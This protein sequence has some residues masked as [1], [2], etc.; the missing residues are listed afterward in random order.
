MI[1]DT[2]IQLATV[3]K[4]FFRS[5]ST[6]LVS[7]LAIV[8]FVELV[9][10]RLRPCQFLL[11]TECNCMNDVEDKQSASELEGFLR[12]WDASQENKKARHQSTKPNETKQ[13]C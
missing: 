1:K 12:C 7:I 9:L 10:D 6:C 5:D 3:F 11:N 13:N 4:K 8:K 2:K